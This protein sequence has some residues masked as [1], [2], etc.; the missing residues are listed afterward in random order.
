MT[1]INSKPRD[2]DVISFDI[3]SLNTL[4][5]SRFTIPVSNELWNQRTKLEQ[6][7]N[8]LH[9]VEKDFNIIT[10]D[11][12]NSSK[13]Y[14]ERQ[15]RIPVQKI[16]VFNRPLDFITSVLQTEK[17]VESWICPKC[18]KT[19]DT[20]KTPISNRQHISTSTFGVIYEQPVYSMATRMSH[21]KSSMI[22]VTKFMREI[23]VGM[24]A[25]QKAFFD[26]HGRDM[27]ENISPF[28]H[29]EKP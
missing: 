18:H 24:M 20:S 2:W 25:F 16:T 5:T 21:E 12:G 27:K 3:H 9:C 29:E 19:N 6:H 14:F 22:W 8:C 15:S 7:R 23:D 4:L 1:G 10:D 17:S 26:E 28:N 13:E 11:E